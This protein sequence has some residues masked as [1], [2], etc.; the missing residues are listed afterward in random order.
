MIMFYYWSTINCISYYFIIGRI[1]KFWI[2]MFCVFL[3]FGSGSDFRYSWSENNMLMENCFRSIN[4]A[5]KNSSS[6]VV[7]EGFPIWP[8]ICLIISGGIDKVI[9]SSI[10]KRITKDEKFSMLLGLAA[11]W[12]DNTYTNNRQIDYMKA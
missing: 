9:I 10:K 2:S 1:R 6:G 3:F 4:L 7:K 8:E 5:I 11:S 12:D